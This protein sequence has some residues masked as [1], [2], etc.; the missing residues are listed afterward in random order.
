M[1][2]ILAMGYKQAYAEHYN[3]QDYFYLKIIHV[4]LKKLFKKLEQEL[5][6]S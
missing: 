5:G 4:L 3:M 6:L 2:Y 1:G